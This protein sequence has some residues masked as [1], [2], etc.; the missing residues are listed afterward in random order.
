VTATTE[1]PPRIATLDIL[2]GVAVMGILAMNAVGFAMPAAAYSNP[3][4]YGGSEGLDLF[5]WTFGF[6]FVDG[7]MRGLFSLL[8]GASLLL[9]TDAAEAK[10]ENPA[11]VHYSRMLW[12]GLFGAIHYYLIWWGDILL[13]Y[14]LVGLAAYWFRHLEPRALGRATAIF[15][16]LAILVAASLSFGGAELSAAAGRPGAAPQ[17]VELWR[18]MAAEVSPP[19]AA[20]LSSDLAIHR[21]GLLDLARYRLPRDAWAPFDYLKIGGLETLAL[22]LMGMIGL[23]TGFL[24]GAWQRRFYRRVA[25]WCILFGAAGASV[26]AALLIRSRFDPA[27][28]FVV[29]FGGTILFR[30]VMIVGYAALIILIV[31]P[32]AIADRISAAGRMAFSN[33]LGTSIVMTVVFHGW[34]LGLYARFSRVELLGFVAIGWLAMLAWSKPW[35]ARFRHGPLEWLWRSLVHGTLQ[36]LRRLANATDSH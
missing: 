18:A 31:R 4:A 22:M 19:T 36:P 2:R 1:P 24:T 8:F 35:L 29:Q 12:L 5:A 23:R 9:I 30:F 10:G 17:V 3:A 26:L 14:A 33:Y 27:T 32:G 25:F 20:Q 16:A 13:H 15:I 21:A 34:G 6:I 11:L 7:K 28:V